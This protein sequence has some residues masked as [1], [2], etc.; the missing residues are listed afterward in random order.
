MKTPPF[1]L[2]AGVLFWGWQTDQLIF[3]VPLALI[4]ESSRILPTRFELSTLE[5]HRVWNLCLLA[6]IIVLVINYVANKG[7]GSIY[8]VLQWLPLVLSPMAVAQLYSSEGKVPGLA[9]NVFYRK[10]E[11]KSRRRVTTI[12]ILYPYLAICILGASAVV[13]NNIWFY[14]GMGLL[15]TWAIWQVRSKRFSWVTW[16]ASWSLIIL[17]GFVGSQGLFQLRNYIDAQV[18][19]WLSKQFQGD[20]DPFKAYTAI[21]EIVELKMDDAILFHIDYEKGHLRKTL[22]PQATYNIYNGAVWYAAKS[23]FTSFTASS[24]T[25]W[26]FE[27]ELDPEKIIKVA[28]DL[29]KG[30]GL[31]LAPNQAFQFE[32]LPVLVMQTNTLGTVRVDKGPE[33]VEYQVAVHPEVSR[34]T[35][36]NENDLKVPKSLQPVLQTIVD[37]LQLASK[38]PGEILKTVDDYFENN[39]GYSLKLI[40]KNN[41]VP[42]LVDFLTRT[43]K[44]HCEYFA[45]AAA[46][47]LRQAGIPARYTFGYSAHEYNWMEKNI[48]VRS[49]DAHAWA[50]AYVNGQWKNFDT[51]P[52]TWVDRQQENASSFEAL[53]DIFSHAGFLYSNFRWGAEDENFQVYLMWMLIPPVLFL[54]WR[55]YS[56]TRLAQQLA[57]TGG[58]GSAALYAVIASD[59]NLIESRLN[60]MGHAREEWE[61]YSRWLRRI[62]REQPEIPV[63][64][65]AEAVD[66]HSRLRFDP[67]GLTKEEATRLKTKIQSWLDTP[68]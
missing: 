58:T 51:T 29:N 17:L 39:F 2:A 46:L 23:P 59:F 4:L 31:L 35:A 57:E 34:N 3:A 50:I 63:A 33:F 61:T 36:P 42:P 11:S 1:L 20:T 10:P 5:F 68:C 24:E 25:R 38:S 6:L 14:W 19:D 53:F 56:R 49:R 37:D 26:E 60:Q 28:M 32:N 64:G 55:I 65:L 44:G 52:S 40:R 48:V 9:F 41:K 7:M 8:V 45:T 47:L 18:V 30:K 67:E 66:L 43:R 22:L 62:H 12:D 15:C 13:E 16:S 21:G 27:K 54:V